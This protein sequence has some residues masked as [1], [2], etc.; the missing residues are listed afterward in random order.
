MKFND[1]LNGEPSPKK[2]IQN[3]TIRD[4]NREALLE[5]RIAELDMQLTKLTDQQTKVYDLES[6][7]STLSRDIDT[8]STKLEGSENTLKATQQQL[9]NQQDLQKSLASIQQQT[10]DVQNSLQTMK[11][12]LDEQYRVNSKQQEEIMS[13]TVTNSL[14]E[15]GQEEAQRK[16][17]NEEENT[18]Y[19]RAEKEHLQEMLR[20]ENG[21]YADALKNIQTHIDNIN[22]LKQQNKFFRA[23][24]ERLQEEFNMERTKS[25]SLQTSLDSLS[26]TNDENKSRYRSSSEEVK[27][28]QNSVSQLLESLTIAEDKNSYMAEKQE[29]LEAALAKP[30]Y[31][32]EASIARNEGFKMPLGGM[33]L[34]SRKSYLGTGKPTLLKFK[35]KESTNDNTE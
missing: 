10:Q 16:H 1:Y 23:S 14:L 35:K 7:N 21:N 6:K 27:D 31:I 34:N 13:L 8:V 9:L 33:A 30:R 19:L 18:K 17:R 20:V 24:V 25:T 4:E 3:F 32:S 2:P 11:L 29:Y 5:K 22:E 15:T 26:F 28:L 12:E